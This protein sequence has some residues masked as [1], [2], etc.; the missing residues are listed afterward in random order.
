MSQRGKRFAPIR[1]LSKDL[2]RVQ[3]AIVDGLRGLEGDV[4]GLEKIVAGQALT[5]SDARVYHGLGRPVK[6]WV[7]V[8]RNANAVVYQATTSPAP[9]QYILLRAS[10]SVTVDVLVF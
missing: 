5:T 2:D 3:D 1:G 8:N 4:L 9:N 7:V 10:A 6:G